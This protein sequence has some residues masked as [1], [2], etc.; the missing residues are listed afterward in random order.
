MTSEDPL[1]IAISAIIA[2]GAE[3]A[4]RGT[5]EGGDSN[6]IDAYENLK[7]LL[8]GELGDDSKLFEAIIG[9]EEAPDSDV[10]LADFKIEIEK[11]QPDQFPEFLVSVGTLLDGLKADP[12]IESK[13]QEFV[14]GPGVDQASVGSE[15]KV[16]IREDGIQIGSSYINLAGDPT[17]EP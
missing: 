16:T 17:T 12:C 4:S 13:L 7:K 11:A 5:A 8:E 14:V 2:A 15:A 3:H 6:A 9:L 10:N 1:T